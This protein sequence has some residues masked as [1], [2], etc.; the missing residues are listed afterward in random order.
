MFNSG[1]D[2]DEEDAVRQWLKDNST[3]VE[4]LKKKAGVS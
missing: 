4:D 1:D 2:V 3:F